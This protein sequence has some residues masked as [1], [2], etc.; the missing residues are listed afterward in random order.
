[1]FFS[2]VPSASAYTLKAEISF[3]CSSSYP[4]PCIQMCDVQ[5]SKHIV[6]WF[7]TASAAV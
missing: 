5:F 6:V 2:L 7:H 1:V 4:Y 3:L